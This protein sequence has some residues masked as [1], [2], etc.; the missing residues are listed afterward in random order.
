[1][2]LDR[3]GFL[4]VLVAGL[5]MGCGTRASTQQ[6]ASPGNQ[7][8]VATAHLMAAELTDADDAPRVG[9]SHRTAESV[10]DEEG[11]K[12]APHHRSDHKTG[13]GFSGYK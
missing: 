2:K 3:M 12:D 11:T 6:V 5:A 9:K 7:P 8:T 10:A 13:G 4:A 1:M